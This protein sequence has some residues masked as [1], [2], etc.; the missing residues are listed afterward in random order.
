[1]KYAPTLAGHKSVTYLSITAND[2]DFPTQKVLLTGRGVILPRE[3]DGSL[4]QTI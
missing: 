2:R 4:A 1:V 3:L